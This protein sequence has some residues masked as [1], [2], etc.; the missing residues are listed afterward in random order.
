MVI[1][2]DNNEMLNK[3]FIISGIFYA[4]ENI[5]KICLFNLN[6]ENRLAIFTFAGKN[7]KTGRIIIA[8][9]ILF[10]SYLTF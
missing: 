3:T 9:Q 1:Y 6:V 4:L 5:L 7:R 10:F 8:C 2:R